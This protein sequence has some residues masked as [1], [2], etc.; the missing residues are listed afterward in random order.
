M[1]KERRM[2]KERVGKEEIRKEENVKEERKFKRII[3]NFFS[4]RVE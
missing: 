1:K 2:N 4:W 3:Y